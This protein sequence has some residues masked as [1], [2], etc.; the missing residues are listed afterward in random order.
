MKRVREFLAEDHSR[1]R[2]IV[3]GGLANLDCF[4]PVDELGTEHLHLRM[5]IRDMQRLLQE[6]A[7]VLQEIGTNALGRCEEQACL[8]IAVAR[9]PNNE[10][11]R[12][13]CGKHCGPEEVITQGSRWSNLW[14]L[15]QI[16]LI[17]EQLGIALEDLSLL[18]TWWH[19]IPMLAAMPGLVVGNGEGRPAYV[20]LGYQA[21]IEGRTAVVWSENFGDTIHAQWVLPAS[22]AAPNGPI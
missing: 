20:D 12:T 11:G 14:G 2:W 19:P 13:L 21:E 3:Q 17:A 22:I 8:D 16:S 15:E 5:S 1:Y 10:N 7:N 4:V 6:A 9:C 18:E